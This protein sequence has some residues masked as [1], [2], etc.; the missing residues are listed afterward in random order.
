[1]ECHGFEGCRGTSD[2]IDRR[3]VRGGLGR[4]P[5]RVYKDAFAC[6]SHPLFSVRDHDVSER[7]DD[8]VLYPALGTPQES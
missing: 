8:A 6:V 5:E 3:D 2:F 7:K 1:M 4:C